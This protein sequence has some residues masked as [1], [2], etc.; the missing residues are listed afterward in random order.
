MNL[1]WIVRRCC[2]VVGAC[3]S[4]VAVAPAAVSVDMVAPGR[5]VFA[6]LL[7]ESPADSRTFYS[8]L[9]GWQFVEH[10]GPEERILADSQE[11]GFLV[12]IDNRES[13]ASESQWITV[14]TVED[15]ES[16]GML[17][18]DRG[19]SIANGPAADGS[20]GR[21][22]VLRDPQGAIVTAYSGPA[23]D[24]APPTFGKWAWFDLFTTDPRA[25]SRFYSDFAGLGVAPI[26]SEDADSHRIF[27]RDG[28]ARA[29]LIA[30]KGEAV[31]PAWVPYVAVADLRAVVAQA[32]TLGATPVA[33]S[34]DAAILLD[35]TGAAIGLQEIGRGG[36]P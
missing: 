33:L 13:D 16:A 7:T 27:G 20:G 22:V 9:F 21:Y 24:P 6:D 14:L 5:F 23:P 8:Q 18:R 15:V 1:H 10:S 4:F 3:F 34:E 28:E 35:P 36:T 29:G 25:A 19:G 31:D 32:E 12:P 17:A 11:I 30:I 2:V 26:S